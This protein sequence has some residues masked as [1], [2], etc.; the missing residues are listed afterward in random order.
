MKIKMNKHITE[1]RSYLRNKYKTDFLDEQAFD[2]LRGYRWYIKT[3]QMSLEKIT[4]MFQDLCKKFDLN[5]NG[6]TGLV[7]RLSDFEKK[8]TLHLYPVVSD[9]DHS[10]TVGHCLE[11]LQLRPMKV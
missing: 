2:C 9:E 3:E 11:I 8:I 7:Y 1:L 6:K 5:E 10:K 4:E